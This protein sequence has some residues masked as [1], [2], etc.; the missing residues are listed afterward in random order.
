MVNALLPISAAAFKVTP[1]IISLISA[2]HFVILDVGI[3]IALLQTYALVSVVI[4]NIAKIQVSVSHFV[5]LIAL[6]E[7]A[8]S[9]INAPALLVISDIIR[10]PT[11]VYQIVLKGVRMVCALLRIHALAMKVSLMMRTRDVCH[12]V[13]E[14]VSMETALH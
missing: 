7:A 14:V 3:L 1:K 11:D 9:L 8:Q 13:Q 5:L 12:S 10:I 2:L 4:Q 6:M